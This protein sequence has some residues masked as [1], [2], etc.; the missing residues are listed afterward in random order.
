M[1]SLNNGRIGKKSVFGM[2]LAVFILICFVASMNEYSYAEDKKKTVKV[3]WFES[4]FY[5]KDQ[6]GR[7]SGYAYEYQRKIS[8]YTGWTYEYIEGNWSE[9]LDMLKKGEIDLL[10]NVSYKPERAES[11]LYSYLPMNTEAYYIYVSSGNDDIRSDDPGTLT[12]KRVA[13]DRGSIQNDLFKEWAE[14]HKVEYEL[15]EVNLSQEE[16]LNMLHDGQFDAYVMNDSFGDPEKVKPLWKIGSSDCYFVVNKDKPDLL[17]ELD[18]ALNRIQDENI[19]YNQQLY[20]KYLKNT[21]SNSYLNKQ[22]TEWLSKHGKIRVGYQD[23]YLAFCAKDEKT[24]ELTGA[25]KDYLDSASTIMENGE[26][27]FEAVAYPTA[28]DELTA[29]KNGEIDCMFPANL[30]AYDGE[31]LGVQLTPPI[32]KTEMDAVV[33]ASEKKEFIKKEHVRVAV[34]EGNTNYELFLQDHYPG[35]E[36]VYFKDTPAGIEGVANGKADCVIISNYRYNNISKKC[37]KLHLDTI[38]TGV[39]LE[40]CFAVREGDMTLYSILSKVTYAVPESTTNAALTY[41]STEDV[42]ISFI[43]I[44]KDH[45]STILLAIAVILLIIILLTMRSIHL[46]KKASEERHKVDDLN[47]KVFVDA[48]TS[49]RNKGAFNDYLQKLQDNLGLEGADDFAIGVFDCDN[50]KMINDQFGHEK[51]DIYIKGACRLICKTFQHSPVF[52]I[53]GDEFAAIL[54]KDDFVNMEDCVK[55]FYRRRREICEAAENKWDEVHVSM[56]IAVYNPDMDTTVEDTVNRADKIMY[57]NKK[58]GKRNRM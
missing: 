46:H 40:Y 43:D 32:M 51:G 16:A 6:L 11:M 8:A 52:R 35:W 4:G 24:G 56:G 30:S 39:D 36:P 10:A 18:M 9:L 57:E 26:I 41:Y 22:E 29:L 58:I 50:L 28:S 25:L 23:N 20:E 21:G 31:E 33:R 48:L 44:I 42:K 53:G 7:R 27:E 2:I 54:E 3:G 55:Y 19:Y 1:D 13:I 47:K 15:V 34:N 14:N 38:Y 5:S 45:L 12:G 37:E 49:V 17:K